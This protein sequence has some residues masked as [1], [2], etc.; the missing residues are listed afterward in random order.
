MT[1]GDDPGIGCQGQLC[2]PPA[3]SLAGGGGPHAA[4]AKSSLCSRLGTSPGTSPGLLGTGPVAD[5]PRALFV[6][7]P[8]GRTWCGFSSAPG[9]SQGLARS[10]PS[11]L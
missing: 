7:L 1:L 10:R 11:S 6:G 8:Q 5:L 2:L 3:R 4:E 9:S